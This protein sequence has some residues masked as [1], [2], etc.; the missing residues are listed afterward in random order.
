MVKK[1]LVMLVVAIV[2]GVAGAAGG[3]FF[4]KSQ[5]DPEKIAAM[6]EEPEFDLKDG[7]SLALND[8]MVALKKTGSKSS[9]LKAS[10]VIVF[11]DE[12]ALA[13]AENMTDYYRD[14]ILGVFEE[15]TAE[16]LNASSRNEM[17]EPIL[18]AIRAL[19]NNEEDREKV[20]AVMI[21]SFIVS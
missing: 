7:S 6:Q 14:A 12:E 2:F 1:I 17:K 20:V 8:V 15:K 21:P 5:F 9:Y 18:E 11:Q 3:V 4:M 10:F 19:Y 16:E 13:T